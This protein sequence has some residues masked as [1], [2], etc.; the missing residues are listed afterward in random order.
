MGTFRLIQEKSEFQLLR[1]AGVRWRGIKYIRMN[2]EK[3]WCG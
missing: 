1:C 2:E 3:K